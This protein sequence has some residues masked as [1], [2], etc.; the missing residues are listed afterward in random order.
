MQLTQGLGVSTVVID[1]ASAEH[2]S[3][4]AEPVIG[5]HSIASA[6][7]VTPH[8]LVASNVPFSSLMIE[9]C[10]CSPQ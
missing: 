4:V 10:L 6:C 3:L 1:G 9:P 5:G 2:L 8:T 7:F